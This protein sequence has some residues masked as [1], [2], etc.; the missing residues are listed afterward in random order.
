ML[1]D[2]TSKAL[3]SFLILSSACAMKAETPRTWPSMASSAARAVAHTAGR[4]FVACV[5][6]REA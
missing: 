6:Q 3:H 1:I 4:S 2:L 5:F